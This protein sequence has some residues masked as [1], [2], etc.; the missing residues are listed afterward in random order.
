MWIFAA[1][2]FAIASTASFALP[3]LL[4]DLEE[5]A[6]SDPL[7]IQHGQVSVEHN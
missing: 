3:D 1:Q 2:A 7:D 6:V 5:D 4:G